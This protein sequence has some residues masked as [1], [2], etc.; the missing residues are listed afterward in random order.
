MT[1]IENPLFQKH[2]IQ[3]RLD[4]SRGWDEGTCNLLITCQL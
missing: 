4:Y 2:C 3:E 1:I